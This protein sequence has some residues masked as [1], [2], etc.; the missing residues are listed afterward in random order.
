MA[1]VVGLAA[2]TISLAKTCST[3]YKLAELMV[4]ISWEAPEVVEEE[5][6]SYRLML[7]TCFTAIQ[8]ARISL[9]ARWPEEEST[10]TPAMR[11]LTRNNFLHDIKDLAL[12][13]GGKVDE[14]MERTAKLPSSLQLK[15][16]YRWY[17][18]KPDF[19]ALLPFMETLKS[20]LVLAQSTLKLESLYTRHSRE[21]ESPTGEMMLIKAEIKEIKHD[22]AHFVDMIRDLQNYRDIN[23]GGKSRSV[24]Q[25]LVLAF[26]ADSMIN[27]GIVPE[28]AP[29]RNYQIPKQSDLVVGHRSRRRPRRRPDPTPR[30]TRHQYGQVSPPS[31]EPATPSST[32]SREISSWRHSSPR[33]SSSPSRSESPEDTSVKRQVH[34]ISRDASPLMNSLPLSTPL[35]PS[36]DGSEVETHS[37]SQIAIKCATPQPPQPMEEKRR[38]TAVEN[39]RERTTVKDKSKRRT[40]PSNPTTTKLSYELISPHTQILTSRHRANTPVSGRISNSAETKP[41]DAHLHPSGNVNIISV[42]TATGLGWGPAPGE[43]TKTLYTPYGEDGKA[44]VVGT[45]EIAFVIP[46]SVELREWFSFTV[47]GMLLGGYELVLGMEVQQWLMRWG[48]EQAREVKINDVRNRVSDGGDKTRRG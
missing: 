34:F 13:L 24:D 31:S 17:R 28:S 30:Q 7:K 4:E 3:V 44:E 35:V 36:N 6:R 1:E 16:N 14:L 26:L 39:K 41:L 23:P 25:N 19:T 9:E 2:A 20:D 40:P 46:G 10:C 15:V 45:V 18:L 42:L 29:P 38:A 47:C 22:M 8:S 27:K 5:I 11:Y 37:S 12:R 43:S 21:K 32:G 48:E 33:S